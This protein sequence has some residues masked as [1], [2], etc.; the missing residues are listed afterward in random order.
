MK[1]DDDFHLE[2]DG[3]GRLVLLHAGERH[4]GVMPVRAFPLAAPEEGL[5]L[6]GTDGRELLWIARLAELSAP[7]RALIDEELAS[8]EFTP[9]IRHIR[10]V[11]TFATPSTWEIATDRG[12]TR[13]VLK[14]E[15]DIRRLGRGA[16]LIADTH[17]IQFLVPDLLALDKRSKRLLERFL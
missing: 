13:L 14:G 16:L 3:H 4:E 5:S 15:E 1:R 2:R 7:L 8:R 12:D 9:V 11:S 10:S 6:V 17:G